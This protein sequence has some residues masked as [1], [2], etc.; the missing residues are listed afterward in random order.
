MKASHHL[1]SQSPHCPRMG[2]DLRLWPV[3]T[4][5]TWT[6]TFWEALPSGSF[7]LC[8]I[9]VRIMDI[10]GT[11][12]MVGPGDPAVGCKGIKSGA[13]ELASAADYDE[14]ARASRVGE[15]LQGELG[16]GILG[17]VSLRRLPAAGRAAVVA[18]A[19]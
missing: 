10:A 14:V 12:M 15:Y 4:L 3:Q 6:V 19:A 13:A 18:A 8:C 7:N 5:I 16:C 17:W 11:G 2:R 1:A 9:L